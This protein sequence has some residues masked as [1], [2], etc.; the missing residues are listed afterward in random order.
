[1]FAITYLS[2]LPDQSESYGLHKIGKYI[3]G[4]YQQNLHIVSID[5]ESSP[6]LCFVMIFSFSILS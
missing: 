1:M 2:R 6:A 5:F 3:Q 4:N